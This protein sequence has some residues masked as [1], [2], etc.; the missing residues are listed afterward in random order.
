[1]HW[2]L[3]LCLFGYCCQPALAVDNELPTTIKQTLAE[4][5]ISEDALSVYMIPINSKKPLWSYHADVS[6]NPASTMKLVT[7]YAALELLGPQYRWKTILAISGKIRHGILK[8]NI[9]IKG[10][11]DPKLT[12]D[13]LMEMLSVLRARGIREIQGN[14]VLDRS[15]FIHP[16]VTAFDNTPEAAYQVLPDALLFNHNT[17]EVTLSSN[18]KEVTLILDPALPAL[19]IRNTLAVDKSL[20]C[21]V[22]SMPRPYFIDTVEGKLTMRFDG[23]FPPNCQETRYYQALDV[24]RYIATLFASLWENSGG[25]WSGQVRMG[26]MPKGSRI[27]STHVS[28]PLQEI[29]VDLNKWS[30][31]P[32]ARLVYLRLGKGRYGSLAKS[33]KRIRQ[34][35]QKKGWATDTLVLENGSGLSRVERISARLLAKMLQ[36]AM[37][38]PYGKILESSLPIIGVDGTLKE[39]LV[40]HSM[41]GQAYLKTGTLVNVKAIAGIMDTPQEKAVIVAI[42]N[43]DQL[44]GG[45]EVLDEVLKHAWFILNK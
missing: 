4:R 31:N 3:K 20:P 25:K 11:G 18:D 16:E 12:T 26:K 36:N 6:R 40:D 23:G 33:E 1:M 15:W 44:Q 32:M 22:K 17:A 7:T 8:G 39:R 28:P 2:L 19:G 42:I 35:M 38:G 27:L 34:W 21:P 14:L 9:Y 37:R 43:Q 24:K 10:S 41:A 45:A 13:D 5:A 30:N 29:L